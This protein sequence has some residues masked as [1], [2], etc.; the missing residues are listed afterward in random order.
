VSGMRGHWGLPGPRRVVREIIDAVDEGRSVVLVR[1]DWTTL[2]GLVEA[3]QA[4]VDRSWIRIDLDHLNARPGRLVQRL[5]EYLGLE[6]D[7]LDATVSSIESAPQLAGRALWFTGGAEA[8]GGALAHLLT[9]FAKLTTKRA[10]APVFVACLTL[11][12]VHP[13]PASDAG[14]LRLWWWGRI[15]PLDTRIVVDDAMPLPRVLGDVDV[16][17]ELATFD[18]GLADQL[19]RAFT[20]HTDDDVRGALVPRAWDDVFGL[21]MD[22]VESSDGPPLQL[23]DAW[24]AGLVEWWGDH[25]SAHAGCLCEHRPQ[26]LRRRVWRGHVAAAMPF[27]EVRRQSLAAWLHDR[28]GLVGADYRRNDIREMEC[29][30]IYFVLTKHPRLR[31]TRAAWDLAVALRHARNALAHLQPLE[32]DWLIRNEPMLRSTRLR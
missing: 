14:L 3:L 16:V 32:R 10:Q 11:A 28:R 9:T 31:S 7:P 17:A 2:D 15:G 1:P 30:E 27:I 6:G 18:L 5:H 20:G 26:D 24:D 29:G 23:I 13:V 4:A 12:Q 25:V 19:A 8:D 21:E 22:A